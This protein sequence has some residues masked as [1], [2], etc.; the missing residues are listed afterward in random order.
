MNNN[1]HSTI[2]QVFWLTY[3]L[4]PALK[5]AHGRVI[6]TGSESHKGIRVHWDDVMLRRRYNPLTAYKQSKLC[7]LCLPKA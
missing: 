1:S 4:L 7:N 5:K 6:M 3:K 2:W